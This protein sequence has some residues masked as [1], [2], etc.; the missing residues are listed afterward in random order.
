MLITL[1]EISQASIRDALLRE[2]KVNVFSFQVL[3]NAGVLALLLRELAE[4][5][6]HK[7]TKTRYNHLNVLNERRIDAIRLHLLPDELSHSA[8]YGVDGSDLAVPGQQSRDSRPV[9]ASG[10]GA[11]I[12]V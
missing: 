3:E 5:L 10:L 9:N 1:R 7:K 11:A 6:P 8:E 2:A 4:F 12:G